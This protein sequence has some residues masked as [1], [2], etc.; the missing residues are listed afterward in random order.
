V[1][2]GVDGHSEVEIEFGFRPAELWRNRHLNTKKK[3]MK[4]M[5]MMNNPKVRNSFFSNAKPN[6]GKNSVG[7][8]QI[9]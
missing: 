4:M 1:D 3:K 6:S 9:P 7:G 8:R 5:M 2:G